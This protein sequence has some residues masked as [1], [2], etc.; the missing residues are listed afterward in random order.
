MHKTMALHKQN[1][2]T[3][4]YFDTQLNLNSSTI[5]YFQNVAY[6]LINQSHNDNN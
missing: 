4:E 6:V 5:E 3:F 1:K 2:C